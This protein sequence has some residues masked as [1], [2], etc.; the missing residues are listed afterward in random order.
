MPLYS[1]FK[2]SILF[3]RSLKKHDIYLISHFIFLKYDNILLFTF[4]RLEN[5]YEQRTTLIN[6]ENQVT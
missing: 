2:Y 3:I 5:K 1:Y 4:L 6:K